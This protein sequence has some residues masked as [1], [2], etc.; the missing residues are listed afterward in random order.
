MAPAW[1]AFPK[2]NKPFFGGKKKTAT[3]SDVATAPQ[4]AP[5]KDGKA[6]PPKASASPKKSNAKRPR[7][8]IKRVDGKTRAY[9]GTRPRVADALEYMVSKKRDMTGLDLT[10]ADLHGLV[11]PDRVDISGSSLESTTLSQVRA[12]NLWAHNTNLRRATAQNVELRG[13]ELNG[14]DLFWSKWLRSRLVGVKLDQA[15][16]REAS[17]DSCHL[18]NL[19]LLN[20]DMTFAQFT[21]CSMRNADMRGATLIGAKFDR[22]NARGADLTGAV[23]S[24]DQDLSGLDLRGAVG[25]DRITIQTRHYQRIEGC[26][27][28]DGKPVIPAGKH[29]DEV[30][31]RHIDEAAE[32]AKA[33]LAASMDELKTRVDEGFDKL[34]RKLPK[35]RRPWPDMEP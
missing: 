35:P 28:V 15:S 16:L 18:D 11:F 14:S 4:P 34:K 26:S 1:T 7:L 19:S 3:D 32:Q 33:E 9:E 2:E 17:F 13:S 22:V 8:V 10:S 31:K 24:E 30:A 21:D 12:G 29:P 25:L 23:V 20:A 27:I 5:Q 6:Q